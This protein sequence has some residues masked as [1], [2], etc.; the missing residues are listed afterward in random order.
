MLGLAIGF[1][2]ISILEN[3]DREHC[4]S[5]EKNNRGIALDNETHAEGISDQRSTAVLEAE[6]TIQILPPH[7]KER[8]TVF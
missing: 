7:S 8:G 3:L 5:I 4:F 6:R 2:N 1:D